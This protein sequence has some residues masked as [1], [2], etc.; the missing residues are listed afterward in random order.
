MMKILNTYRSS[1]SFLLREKLITPAV[2]SILVFLLLILFQ[3]FDY[4]SYALNR[5]VSD[6][7]LSSFLVFVITGATR[8]IFPIFFNKSIDDNHLSIFKELK[9]AVLEGML[10]LTLSFFVN[11]LFVD[12]H[13]IDYLVWFK[14][15]IKII[16]I[17]EILLWPLAMFLTHYFKI[18]P[19]SFKLKERALEDVYN[20]KSKGV[21]EFTLTSTS[22]AFKRRYLRIFLDDLIL[23]KSCDNY[24]EVFYEEDDTI[25]SNLIRSTISS[26]NDMT[27]N[28]PNL[29]QCHRS[30]LVNID[31]IDSVKG[32]SRGYLLTLKGDLRNIP[33]SRSKISLFKDRFS[34]L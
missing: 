6:A 3:P 16:L 26:V 11:I 10:F 15:S 27:R 33:V 1:K 20:K 21:L 18:A 9:K 30:Y 13:S 24:I 2:L 5:V 14:K 4:R 22:K 23:I 29:M 7:M 34:H 8:N 31:K 12:Y 17:F 32:N 19:I 25:Q 28:Y